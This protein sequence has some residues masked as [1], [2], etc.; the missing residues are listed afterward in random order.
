MSQFRNPQIAEL[1]LSSFGDFAL[2]AD[3]AAGL[4]DSADSVRLFPVDDEGDRG[5]GD[6]DVEGVPFARLNESC[7]GGTRHVSNVAFFPLEQIDLVATGGE[8]F[9][10]SR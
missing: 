8:G 3:V 6:C 2:E 4:F 5:A 9:P 7:A 10:R 1:K